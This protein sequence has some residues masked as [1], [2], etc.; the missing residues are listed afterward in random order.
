MSVSYNKLL[1][2]L[3]D[4]VMNE[5]DLGKAAKMSPNTIV[6]FSKNEMVSLEFFVRI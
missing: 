4:H 3:I 6:W 1:E 5:S 2:R